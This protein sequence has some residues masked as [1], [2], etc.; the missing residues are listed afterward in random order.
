MP[1]SAKRNQK[2]NPNH[3]FKSLDHSEAYFRTMFDT[4][5]VGI[6]IMSLDRKL[7]DANPAFYHMF[8]YLPDELIGKEPLI[9][10]YPEDYP[11]STRQF[12]ELVSGKLDY[13]W[14]ERRYR[15]KNGEIFWANVTMSMVRDESF[16]PL[17][18]VGMLIDIDEQKKTLEKLEQSEERFRTI[19]ENTPIGIA[20]VGLDGRTITVNPGILKMTGYSEQELLSMSGLE[21][22]HPDDRPA[23]LELMAGLTSGKSKNFEVE[24][25]FIRKNGEVYWVRQR[26]SSINSPD[27]KPTYIVVMVEDIDD[28]KRVLAELRDS[29]QHFR[30]VFENSAIGISLIG[31]DRH[32]ITTNKALLDMTGYSAE[33]LKHL[34][35]PELSYPEDREIG[36]TEFW[37]VVNGKR[38]SYQVEKRYVRKNGAIYWVRL[39]VSGVHDDDGQLL[40][41]ISMTEDITSMKIAEESFRASETRLRA[42]FENTSVGIALTD[43]DRKI[44]QVN[45]AA[46][47]ITG[48]S[49]GEL[50]QINPIELSLP[51]DRLIGQT[52]L[53]EMIHGKR[54]GM[55]VERRFVRKDGQVFWGRVTYSLIRDFL[56]NPQYLIG[57]IED[58]NE[59]KQAAEKL[60]RQEMEY[61]HT[62][63]KHVEERTHE[64]SETN[65]RLVHEIEQ[66]QAAEEAL[67]AKAVEEAVRAERT[68]LAHDLH[69]AVTQTLFSASLIAEVLPELWEINPDEARKSNDELR[70]LTRGALAEM[71][72]L[73]FELRPAA[74]TQARFS[75]LIKQLSEAVIGRARIPI[76]LVVE[77]DY[78]L[79]AEIKV[80]FYRIAQECLNNIAKYSRASQ[81]DI[82]IRLALSEAHMEIIDNGIG[83]DQSSIKS[84]SLGMRIM[85]DRAQAIHA[86]LEIS[87]VPGNGTQVRLDWI[88]DAQTEVSHL[89]E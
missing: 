23:A 34:T 50:Q 81:I 67:A 18:L 68:R 10:T 28:Q 16:N 57:L 17:Y 41:L 2:N 45:E 5:A 89:S 74:L 20:L 13:F 61:L 43:L 82:A 51:E 38:D 72:T 53:L 11:G 88:D 12:K 4:A 58:I 52:A 26:I 3:V 56:G 14:G 60:A 42:I 27:G 44:I 40:Y 25:R 79:P 84:T 37:A 39:T 21:F 9:V 87:S 49:L 70:Q 63:E 86:S 22:T 65:L 64:L 32:P 33:E 54:A 55:I 77:G 29:E 85:H 1:M 76:N 35:G 71:R 15:R 46:A 24:S 78:K 83:F 75:D 36:N 19:F 69:D 30:A 73:L 59:E 48:Y 80:A 7:I 8:G 62:L 66:R 31:L 6:G 47:R